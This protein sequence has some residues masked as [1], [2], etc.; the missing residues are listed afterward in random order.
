M[1]PLLLLAVSCLGCLGEL[2]F[3]VLPADGHGI[4]ELAHELA[5]LV[6]M[7]ER[8]QDRLPGAVVDEPPAVEGIVGQRACRRDVERSGRRID[9]HVPDGPG[10]PGGPP[11]GREL[12][13]ETAEYQDQPTV[14]RGDLRAFDVPE[15]GTW[16]AERRPYLPPSQVG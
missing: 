4:G 15:P 11:R 7:V 1:L 12:R 13:V 2:Q 16:R 5:G 3:A 14:N 10:R 6:V 9:R 8:E